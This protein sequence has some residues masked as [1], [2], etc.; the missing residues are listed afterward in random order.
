MSKP[1]SLI[2][3]AGL[4]KALDAAA[5]RNTVISDNIANANSPNYQ[6]KTVLFDQKL[7]EA[8]DAHAAGD[9]QAFAKLE[10]SVEMKEG[11]TDIIGEM[12]SLSKN[13]ILYHAYSERISKELSNLKWIVENAGR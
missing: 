9:R 3:T 7:R 13:Q 2:D 1:F 11:P 4:E 10:P 12:V 8:V 5:L 6:A